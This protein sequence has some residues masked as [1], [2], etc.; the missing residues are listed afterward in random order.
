[1]DMATFSAPAGMQILFLTGLAWLWIAGWAWRQRR[2]LHATLPVGW[3]TLFG[4][5]HTLIAWL[6]LL[7]S[8]SMAFA[9]GGR[10]VLALPGAWLA[11]NL[12]RCAA[13]GSDRRYGLR[14]VAGLMAADAGLGLLAL[15]EIFVAD[16]L[17]S[18]LP[19]W[20]VARQGLDAACGLGVLTLCW[21]LHRARP[22][23]QG[24]IR[25]WAPV[26]M[27]LLGAICG[28]AL[29]DRWQASA[30]AET[31]AVLAAGDAAPQAVG[32]VGEADTNAWHQLASE[33]LRSGLPLLLVFLLLGIGLVAAHRLQTRS[34]QRPPRSATR[35][36]NP[37]HS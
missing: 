33:R 37:D 20:F 7:G 22:M 36:A 6:P 2:H 23:D 13:T 1:M 5:V 12:G 8:C 28:A 26:A 27:F 9:L 30:A 15:P 35:H 24:L 29:V 14:A 25:R 18:W 17:P 21:W 16:P 11:W 10:G 34:A 31:S 4:A 32:V 3:L 19:A